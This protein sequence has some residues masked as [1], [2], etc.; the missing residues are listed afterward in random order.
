MSTVKSPVFVVIHAQWCGH[1][2]NMQ[3]ELDKLLKTLKN[4]RMKTKIMQVEEYNELS[5]HK[6]ADGLILNLKDNKAASEGVPYIAFHDTKNLHV[7]PPQERTAVNM[8]RF[9]LDKLRRTREL[10]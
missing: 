10:E 7:F 1:C 5:S 3:P 9:I 8:A 6:K 2:R 4:T